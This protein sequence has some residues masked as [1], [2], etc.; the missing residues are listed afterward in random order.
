MRLNLS[1]PPARRG[2]VVVWGL[3]ATLPIGGI[4]W[5]VLHYLIP[6][7]RLGFDVWYVED[8]YRVLYDMASFSPTPH[9]EGCRE[10]IDRVARFMTS[11]GLGDR[12]ACRPLGGELVGA[13]DEAGLDR[14]Y[15]DAVMAINLCGAED[16]GARQKAVKCRVYLETDP[17]RSQ[18]LVAQGNAKMIRILDD[19]HWHF[20][21]GGNFGAP[22][23]RVP[24]ERYRWI[25]TVPP[26][27]LDLWNFVPAPEHDAPLTTVLNWRHKS[28]DV[29]WKGEAWRFTKDGQFTRFLSLPSR[30]ALPLEMC[31]GAATASDLEEIS[32]HG[33][34]IKPSTDCIDPDR[35]RDYIR[36]SAG[37]FSAAKELVVVTRSGWFSDRT[38]CFLAAGRPAIVQETGFSNFLP[39]GLGLFGFSNLDEAVAAIDAVAADYPRHAGAAKEIAHEYFDA[40][41]VVANILATVGVT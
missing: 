35:Y 24:L 41:R 10:N 23:C 3:M 34:S 17:V 29:E 39:T 40:N 1:Y 27:C 16:L 9:L 4:V 5:Q 13:L 7:R 32:R 2:K 30:S 18:V 21:Y 38:V 22:D 31:V 15:A 20:T 37:E 8:S 14:L 19:H 25:K 36:S 11:V 26:V 12:W 33:W 28:Q 6:L